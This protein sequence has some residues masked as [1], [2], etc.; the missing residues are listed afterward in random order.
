MAEERN[1]R[2][3]PNLT[4]VAD[5]AIEIEERLVSFYTYLSL[6]LPLE[7]A[8]TSIQ[9]EEKIFW[10]LAISMVLEVNCAW[11]FAPTIGLR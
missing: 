11:N 2:L 1:W 4:L 9:P 3:G 6:V 10:S 7:A 5:F 8:S